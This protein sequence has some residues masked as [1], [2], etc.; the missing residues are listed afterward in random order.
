[1]IWFTADEHYGHPKI[2]KYCNRP[3]KNAKEMDEVLIAVIILN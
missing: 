1:M 3:F 2:I